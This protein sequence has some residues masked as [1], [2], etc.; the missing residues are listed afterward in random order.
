MT[1]TLNS[2]E[3]SNLLKCSKSLACELARTGEVPAILLGSQWLF[4]KSQLM[5]YLQ[6]RARDEQAVRREELVVREAMVA[7]MEPTKV[8]G[9]PRRSRQAWAVT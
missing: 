5:D 6:Q 4:V 3:A 2:E 7:S 9:R 8:R 1:E